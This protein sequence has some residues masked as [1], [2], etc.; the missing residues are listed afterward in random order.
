MNDEQV[1]DVS[2]EEVAPSVPDFDWRSQIPE[3]IA[4]HKSLDT[5]RDVPSL[6]KGYVHAQSMIGADKV[7][8]PPSSATP[9]EWTDFYAKTGRPEE[10]T[11]Y[12]LGEVD[13]DEDTGS[14][15][16]ELAHSAGLRPDQAQK[17]MNGYLE[18]AGLQQQNSEADVT[19]LYEDGVKEMQREYG[20]AFEERI[21][22]GDSV[23]QQFGNPELTNLQLADGRALKDHPEMVRLAVNLGQYIKDKIGE[24]QLLGVK[25]RGGMTPDEANER[26]REI[27]RADG[28]LFD[29]RHPEHDWHV[30]ESL[31][32]RELTINE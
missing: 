16:K 4:G 32:L 14:W 30:Q 8:I 7:V 17:L 5:I 10:P 12:E 11:G 6:I 28:P 13:I 15:F 22:A 3:E 31:R 27:T 23:L 20:S 24:D 2:V 25:S 19:R 21:A 26:L 29:S 9:D 1:A 18:R